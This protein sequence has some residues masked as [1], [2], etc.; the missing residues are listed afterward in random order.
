MSGIKRLKIAEIDPKLKGQAYLD[1][2]AEALSPESMASC[3]PS[4]YS[5][6]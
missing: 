4:E 3:D 1:A 6:K 2:V 5:D